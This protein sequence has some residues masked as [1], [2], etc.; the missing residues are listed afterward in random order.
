MYNYFES[1][2]ISGFYYE[3]SEKKN[4][5]FSFYGRELVRFHQLSLEMVQNYKNGEFLR[6]PKKQ[7]IYV[8]QKNYE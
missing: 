7:L 2:V 1:N 6:K 3:L 5:L 4:S 8:N